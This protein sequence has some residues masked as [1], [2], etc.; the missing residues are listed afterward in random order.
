MAFKQHF[1]GSALRI[2]VLHEQQAARF[3]GHESLLSHGYQVFQ[4]FRLIRG[5]GRGMA[6]AAAV[7][8]MVVMAGD[9]VRVHKVRD[10]R[11][12]R[13]EI[14]DFG[15]EPFIFGFADIGRVADQQIQRFR[16]QERPG[17][18]GADGLEPLADIVAHGVLA[19]HG[20]RAAGQIDHEAAPV[21]AFRA[22]GHGD[23]AAARTQIRKAGGAVAAFE[24]RFDE[25]L[26]FRAGNEGGGRDPEVPAVEFALSEKVG[27]GFAIG[28]AAL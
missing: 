14:T 28:P 25:V 17:E 4:P 18:V 12:D 6:V 9:L 13:F 1:Y 20:Q 26:G 3:E 8:M 16:A 21:W 11:R 7:I 24:G 2:A 27:G 22:Q 23:A 5:S 10:E 15:G 19:G